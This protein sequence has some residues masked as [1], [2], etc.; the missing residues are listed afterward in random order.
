MFYYIYQITNLVNGK[1][2]V[3]VH[4]TGNLDDGYMGSGKVIKRAI[5]KYGIDNFT[6]DVLEFFES[7]E[8][9]Y[10]KEKE[11]VTENFLERD[12]VYNLRRGGLGG[13]DHINKNYEELCIQNSRAR[14]NTDKKLEQKL[15][16][17]WRSVI[18]KKASEAAQHPS[19]KAKRRKT[20][21]DRGIR[22]DASYMHTAE[23]NEKRKLA[24]KQNGHSIGEKNSQFGTCVIS[25][26][27]LGI[28]R[29][30][31]KKHLL[32]EYIDQGWM[33]GAKK[34]VFEMFYLD[35]PP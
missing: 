18:G 34:K 25:Y 30:L 9:M 31:I 16:K 12:E 23:V 22:S 6:K 5:K 1:I 19:S 27:S 28:K 10:A 17:D 11:V 3:G 33:L 26:P 29:K 24:Y 35:A 32:C 2:Y 15:G 7:E 20:L 21:L 4:K 14:K 13:F 8:L